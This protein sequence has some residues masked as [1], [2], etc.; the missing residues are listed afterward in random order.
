MKRLKE[1][2]AQRLVRSI[3]ERGGRP[4]EDPSSSRTFNKEVLRLESGTGGA[5]EWTVGSSNQFPPTVNVSCRAALFERGKLRKRIR[6]FL[7]DFPGGG[8]PK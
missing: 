7:T 8:R 1:T 3:A 4:D 5:V 2:P 6:V